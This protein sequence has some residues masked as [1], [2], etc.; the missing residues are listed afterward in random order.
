MLV[1][2]FSKGNP[3]LES[4]HC[5]TIEVIA[6]FPES[7]HK[8]L[9]YICQLIEASELHFTITYALKNQGFKRRFSRR[10]TFFWF[11]RFL[12][13]T[14]NV[15]LNNIKNLLAVGNIPL[16]FFMESSLPVKKLYFLKSVEPPFW[17][18]KGPFSER[19]L[20]GLFYLSVKKMYTF[21]PLERLHLSIK[22]L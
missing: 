18:P 19:L 13:R 7:T 9:L 17:F 22:N 10:R 12:K 15:F 2:N 16:M 6:C 20:K 14:I 3:N 4:P 11:P 21:C 8:G 1:C 5:Y